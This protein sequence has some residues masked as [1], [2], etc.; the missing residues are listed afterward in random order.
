MYLQKIVRNR[1]VYTK[2]LFRKKGRFFIQQI[3]QLADKRRG[4]I[5]VEYQSEQCFGKSNFFSKVKLQLLLLETKR[6]TLKSN[7]WI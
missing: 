7:R 5:G 6:R 3:V 1:I 2:T 4:L